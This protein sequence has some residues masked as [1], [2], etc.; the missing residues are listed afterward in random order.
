[1]KS[2]P[3]PLSAK[4]HGTFAYYTVKDR[5]PEILAKALDCL[6]KEWKDWRPYSCQNVS[7]QVKE[8]EAKEII[9]QLSKL[10]YL[11][12][13]DKPL[14]KLEYQ[15]MNDFCIWTDAMVKE[16]AKQGSPLSWFSSRW[17]FVECYLYRRVQDIMLAYSPSMFFHTFDAFDCQKKASL[18]D[19]IVSAK[20]IGNFVT[21]SSNVTDW[22]EVSLWGNRC[23][24]SLNSTTPSFDNIVNSLAE[25]RERIISNDTD[26]LIRK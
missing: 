4:H 3:E 9:G 1:M 19:N 21:T 26:N 24:L 13:T 5:L 7:E 14:E 2:L 22:I 8:N 15:N 25:L 11:L 18:T 6:H 23:D 16:E 20:S 17:L 10:R 12:M